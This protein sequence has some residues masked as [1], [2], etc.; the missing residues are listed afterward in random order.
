M[1]IIK[2]LN[3]GNGN[4]GSLLNTFNLINYPA[5][6]VNNIKEIIDADLLVL[7]GVGSAVTTSNIFKNQVLIDILNNRNL[8][9]KPILGI[10]LGAQLFFEYLQESGQ[11]GLGWENGSVD[12]MYSY[13][14]GWSQ[15]N[16]AQLV[17]NRLNIGLNKNDS[18]YFNHKFKFPN[19]NEMKLNL[20]YDAENKIPS[21]FLKNHLC[22]IQFHPEKSQ[23]SGTKILYNILKIHYDL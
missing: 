2:I 20:I 21:I 18:F 22:G 7:P 13:N 9:Q 3:Y 17:N 6:V 1:K 16:W 5:S 4:I 8:N 14:T 19:S 15:L 10:C 11:D 23:T 12:E